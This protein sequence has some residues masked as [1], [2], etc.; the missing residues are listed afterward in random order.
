MKL[1]DFVEILSRSESN[2][3]NSERE[4]HQ[5]LKTHFGITNNDFQRWF[6]KQS[7]QVKLKFKNVQT[8]NKSS[9]N[10]YDIKY[11][12]THNTHKQESI[13][14]NNA[15]L[16]L[17]HTFLLNLFK[18][19]DYVSEN[20]T[21]FKSKELQNRAVLVSQYLINFEDRFFESDLGLNKILCGV[22]FSDV[23]NTN[24]KLTEKE[25]NVCQE[26]L[27]SMIAHWKILKNTSPQSLQSSFLQRN[28]KLKK[29]EDSWELTVEKR[30]IDLLLNHL[31][32]G[33]GIIKTPWMKK[34]LS[35]NWK[36]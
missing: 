16:V 20:N 3:G 5:F 17:T 10:L 14:I 28:A 23:I 12:K 8:T 11:K 13:Y 25:K 6:G 18:K 27:V 22:K 29:A 30:S 19:L 24:I 2:L 35:C 15:G 7:D 4:F 32:W 26:L 21:T 34:Y 36:G 31:P 33:I 1:M 9:T